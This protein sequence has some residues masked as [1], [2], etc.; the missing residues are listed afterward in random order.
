MKKSLTRKMIS[1]K[2]DNL[3]PKEYAKFLEQLK[4]DIQ[5]AQLQAALAVT[6]ELIMLYWRT[7]KSLSEKISREKWGAKTIEQLANDIQTSFP[8][9][10]GFSVRNLVY[11][12]KFADCYQ[13]S[14]YAAAAAQIP[15]GHNMV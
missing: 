9:V 10:S 6:K 7:G 14:I 13:E 1:Q 15:W 8:D 3:V 4:K 2:S 12:R 5:Q 11:M